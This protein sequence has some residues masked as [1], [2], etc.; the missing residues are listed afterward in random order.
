MQNE[1][2][3]NEEPIDVQEALQALEMQPYDIIL[4]DVKMPVMNGLEATRAY[5]KDWPKMVQRL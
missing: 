4:M 5:E 1:T 2:R 3:Q